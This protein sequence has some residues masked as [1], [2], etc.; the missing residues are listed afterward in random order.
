MSWKPTD[1]FPSCS[2][3]RPCHSPFES[4]CTLLCK[5]RGRIGKVISW[6]ILGMTLATIYAAISLEKI[7]ELSCRKF[8]FYFSN[9]VHFLKERTLFVPPTNES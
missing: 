8:Q 4:R 6:A 9:L 1:V 3:T 5:E 7:H 2:T